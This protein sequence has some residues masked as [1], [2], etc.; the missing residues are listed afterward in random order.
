MVKNIFLYVYNVYVLCIYIYVYF[1]QV[2]NNR[3]L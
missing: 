2:P 1:I 3:E